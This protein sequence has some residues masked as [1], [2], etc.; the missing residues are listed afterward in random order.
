MISKNLNGNAA[1]SSNGFPEPGIIP[2]ARFYDTYKFLNEGLGIKMSI[3]NAVHAPVPIE[4]AR[5]DPKADGC[6]LAAAS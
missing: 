4:V 5:S 6:L 3:S 2:T 1:I